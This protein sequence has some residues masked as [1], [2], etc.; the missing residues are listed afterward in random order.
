MCLSPNL[1]LGFISRRAGEHGT[2]RCKSIMRP[3]R[4]FVRC[5]SDSAASLVEKILVVRILTFQVHNR[6]I[7]LDYQLVS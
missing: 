7:Q 6:V 1:H 3:V 4:G 5:S 2:L